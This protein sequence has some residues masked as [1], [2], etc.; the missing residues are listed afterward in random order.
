MDIGEWNASAMER[1]RAKREE[2]WNARLARHQSAH[3]RPEPP[4]PTLWD[5]KD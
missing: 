2:E 5:P 4:V 3:R 1:A